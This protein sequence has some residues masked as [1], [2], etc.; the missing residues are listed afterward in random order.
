MF[1]RSASLS[2][3]GSFGST[4]S[5]SSLKE[6]CS[7]E[8][9][10]ATI[11]SSKCSSISATKQEMSCVRSCRDDHHILQTL[12]SVQEQVRDRKEERFF[13]QRPLCQPMAQHSSESNLQVLHGT[14]PPKEQASP[15]LHQAL[16]RSTRQDEQPEDSSACQE[17]QTLR[18]SFHDAIPKQGVLH[19]QMQA[20]CQ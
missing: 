1:V 6:C 10:I 18:K 14:V 7:S 5:K 4:N 3:P 8:R 19:H 11:P 16:L 9:I 2:K 20:C 15:L 13:L 17:L 12:P